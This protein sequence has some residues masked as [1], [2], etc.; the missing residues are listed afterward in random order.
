VGHRFN[1]G[2]IQNMQVRA[3]LMAA[4]LTIERGPHERGTR[5]RV[6]LPLADLAVV[7]EAAGVAGVSGPALLTETP[8]T[9]C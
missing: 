6:C 3:Q 2:G 9:S 1:T 4:Q 8:C 5:V 7:K